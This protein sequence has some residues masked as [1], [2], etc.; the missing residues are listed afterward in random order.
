M[1]LSDYTTARLTVFL[2]VMALLVAGEPAFA[3]GRIT[4]EKL[5]ELAKDQEKWLADPVTN[6][7]QICAYLIVPGAIPESQ[8]LVRLQNDLKEAKDTQTKATLLYLIAETHYWGTFNEFKKTKN[9]DVFKNTA[10]KVIPAYL[11]AFDDASMAGKGKACDELRG[12]LVTRLSQL[13]TTSL[14][15]ETLPPDLKK[16]M[17]SR[18]INKVEGEKNGTASWTLEAK[19]KAYRNLG[20]ADRLNGRIPAEIPAN[21]T[22]TF[23]AMKLAL[24]MGQKDDA[25]RFAQAIEEKFPREIAGNIFKQFELFKVYRDT[26]HPRAMPCIK[27]ICKKEPSGY[28]ELYLYS[29]KAEPAMSA[30]DR[31]KYLDTYVAEMEKSKGKSVLHY[32]MAVQELMKAEDYKGT[33]RFTE[34]GLKMPDVS[35]GSHASYLWASKGM[36]HKKLGENDKAL[37]AF[38][39]S[40][41]LPGSGKGCQLDDFSRKN[42]A[43]LEAVRT[44]K[45]TKIEVEL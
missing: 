43:E 2:T 40:I 5:A 26:D 24:S 16:E 22:N 12:R 3:V 31:A 11:D 1:N 7:T 33:L 14:Y 13:S 25:L 4:P 44:N 41:N 10:A 27:E 15:G 9:K 45:V 29:K 18:F 30:D 39:S 8:L 20:I 34:E 17:V 28:L 6:C 37:E 21:F 36:S 19:G 35:S 38:R 23:E 42:I 32:R